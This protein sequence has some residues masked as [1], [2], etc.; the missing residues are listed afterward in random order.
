V[1]DP[2]RGT[3]HVLTFTGLNAGGDIFTANA[4]PVGDSNQHY[5]VKFDY[6]GLAQ[7]GSVPGNLGGF[8]GVFVS[9]SDPHYWIAGTDQ[10]GLNTPLS[11]E[12]TDDGAWH[13]YE[14]DITPIVRENHLTQVHLMVEDWNESG[15]VPGDAY[16]DD[17]Q[18]VLTS[19]LTLEDIVPCA[20]P[21]AGGT[22]RNHGQYVSAV[23][24]ATRDLVKLGIITK[25]Q[26]SAF[27]SEAAHSHCGSKAKTKKK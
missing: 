2:L 3:N 26:R 17:I 6:L 20:G 8:L 22:W 18:L 19:G 4:L 7:T 9:I 15:G 24:A 13:H 25:R 12:L 27:I 16:F 5:V 11:I 1:T 14:I 10:R 23:A 21:S